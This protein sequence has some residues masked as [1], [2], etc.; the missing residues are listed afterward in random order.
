MSARPL[1]SVILP[2]YNGERY[3]AETIESV[4]A[5]TYRP[6][7][8]IVV[9]DGS[10]DGSGAVARSY[11][12]RYL[13]QANAGT[14]A[15]RNTGV[16]LSRGALLAH[17][18]ADDLWEP[19]KVAVQAA[20]LAV[21]AALDAVSGHLVEFHSPD[22]PD[23]IRH[24]LRPPR[25]RMPGHLLQAMLIRRE[26]HFGVGPFETRWTIG[27]DMSW[28]LRALDAGLRLKILP[29]L[30]LRRRLH[31][32]NKGLTQRA[33]AGQRIEILKAALDRRRGQP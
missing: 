21:D 6:L 7:E 10:T 9:D 25:E 31:A 12:V 11:G 28:Y 23:E 30:V 27:Q 29:D 24:R 15:A 22:L 18:D 8:V 26:A 5:Q 17:M 4:L 20:A 14:A 13:R 2:V 33:H 3:L 19:E 32:S 16:G 1:A